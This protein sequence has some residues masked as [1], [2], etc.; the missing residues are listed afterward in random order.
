MWAY[1]LKGG[2][3]WRVY[4]R[5]NKGVKRNAEVAKGVTKLVKK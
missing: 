1:T 4:E 5:R 3:I 2:P